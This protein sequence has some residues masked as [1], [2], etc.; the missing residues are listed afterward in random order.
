M[1][2][3]IAM[4]LHAHGPIDS[5]KHFTALGLV[6]LT[7]AGHLPAA[8]A[9]P[10]CASG[11]RWLYRPDDMC[12]ETIIDGLNSQ[13]IASISA[14]AF[15]PDQALYVARPATRE[16]IRLPSDHKGWFSTPEVFVADLPE[17]PNGLTFDP[18]ESTWYISADTT[19]IRVRE[20]QGIAADRQTIV[21]NL[22]GGAGG[23][24]GNIRIGPDRRLYV[25]KA[26]SCDNC[27]E[28]DPRRGALLSFALDGSD[29]QIVARGLRD[30]YDFDWNPIDG[31]LYIVDDERPTMPA[32]LNALKRPGADFG[33]PL[34]D[35]QG[36]P[37]AGIP[38]AS[39]DACKQ[40][41]LPVMT[42]APGSHPTGVS[43]YQGNAFSS[44]R[45]GML[46]ALS[47]SWNTTAI[48]GYE[49]DL[50]P[51]DA[52][53]KPGDSKRILPFSSQNSTDASLVRTSFYPY[54]MIGLAI[55]A[56]GWIYVSI[57]EGRVHRFRPWVR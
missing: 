18:V 30:S 29:P 6:A 16:I 41:V 7:F 5:I 46:V 57:A 38:G 53:G 14:L 45:G 44:Y 56:E 31:T 50:I 10:P 37:V 36:Q 17:P 8:P 4:K 9:D 20:N 11:V 3:N 12:A 15:G 47:G 27:V 43:F 34:C 13:G 26:S 42:F 35:F 55:S 21:S 19:I 1:T 54:H 33:W 32:E 39:A 25:A 2:F 48:T 49:L 22:P 24:L 51:F 52:N 40:T 23:W 28:S